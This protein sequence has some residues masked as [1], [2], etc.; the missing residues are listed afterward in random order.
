MKRREN[1][2]NKSQILVQTPSN[3][4]AI[5]HMYHSPTKYAVSRQLKGNSGVSLV[6]SRSNHS[7]VDSKL[8]S[9]FSSQQVRWIK[10]SGEKWRTGQKSGTMF[11][12]GLLIMLFLLIY[13]FS[14]EVALMCSS[15]RLD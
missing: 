4:F 13:M 5:H 3:F 2:S 15:C 10:D 14:T 8:E 12:Y 7:F 11:E 1:L 9:Q 6:D